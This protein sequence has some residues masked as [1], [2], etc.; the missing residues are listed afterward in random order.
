MTTL[1]TTLLRRR[2]NVAE[3]QI[4]CQSPMS[5]KNLTRQGS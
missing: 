5:A 4:E 3:I 1:G 2:E